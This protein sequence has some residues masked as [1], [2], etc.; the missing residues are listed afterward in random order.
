MGVIKMQNTKPIIIKPLIN[1]F[2]KSV[3]YKHHINVYKHQYYLHD[4]YMDIIGQYQIN[5]FEYALFNY[6]V[7]IFGYIKIK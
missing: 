2:I 1:L 5:K 6:M 4:L 7:N 3:I